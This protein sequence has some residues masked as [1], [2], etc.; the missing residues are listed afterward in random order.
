[1]STSKLTTRCGLR[2]GNE[3]WD[4]AGDSLSE[5]PT[6]GLGCPSLCHHVQVLHSFDTSADPT[7][8]HHVVPFSGTRVF[9]SKKWGLATHM[10]RGICEHGSLHLPTS[11]WLPFTL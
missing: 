11:F 7:K 4:V 1:M 2:E 5:G 9:L 3:G 8:R 10:S 6:R